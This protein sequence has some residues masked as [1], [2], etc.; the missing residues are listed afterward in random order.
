VATKKLAKADLVSRGIRKIFDQ[1][2]DDSG[3]PITRGWEGVDLRPQFHE[4]NKC[5]SLS[6]QCEAH[7][8]F[9]STTGD[10]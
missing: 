3:G 6:P 4:V 10:E 7:V 5:I 2:A 1:Q 9:T 8:S